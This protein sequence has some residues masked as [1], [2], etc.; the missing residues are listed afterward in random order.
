LGHGVGSFKRM[1]GRVKDDE[2]SKNKDDK[3]T[4]AQKN[5]LEKEQ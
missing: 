4:C 1:S 2:S 3:L 5:E